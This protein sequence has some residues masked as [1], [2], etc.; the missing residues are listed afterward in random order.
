MNS[1]DIIEIK[2]AVIEKSEILVVKD[3]Y[4]NLLEVANLFIIGFS[5]LGK[6]LT[7]GD[8]LFDGGVVK[9]Y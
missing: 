3:K 6:Y 8:L 4:F 5:H 2:E 1:S 9:T 7:G